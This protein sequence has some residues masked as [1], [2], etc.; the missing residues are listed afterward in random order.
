MK[1]TTSF[2]RFIALM[3]FFVGTSSCTSTAQNATS[4]A[5]FEAKIVAPNV[6][7]VDVRTPQEFANGH[8]E[9][10]KNINFNHPEFKQKIALLDKNKPIAVYCGVG[11][12]SGKAS[13]ILVKLGFKDIT[14]LAGGITAW[15]AA[16]KKVVK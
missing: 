9:N 16:H 14:D 12:R 3:F 1:K 7:L 13:K 4:P 2:L 6:Q 8:L 11:G 15:L 10:A 5:A